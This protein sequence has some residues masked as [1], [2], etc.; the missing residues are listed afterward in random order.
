MVEVFRLLG[1]AVPDVDGPIFDEREVRLIELMVG[2][3]G[4]AARR[5]GDEI[6]RSI[7]TALAIV[8]ESAVVGLRR[9]RR[10]RASTSRAASSTGP[11]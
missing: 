9:H 7:G 5:I 6:L 2:A 4:V 11:R 3:A 10:G 1:V 8:A